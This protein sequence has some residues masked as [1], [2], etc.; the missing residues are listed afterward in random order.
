MNDFVPNS[1]GC[2]S[3]SKW[4]I[5]GG[6]KMGVNYTDYLLKGMIPRSF[7]PF[8]KPPQRQKIHH[9]KN[10]PPGDAIRD[11]DLPEGGVFP[12][13]LPDGHGRRQLRDLGP[14]LVI[15]EVKHLDLT[16]FWLKLPKKSMWGLIAVFW[17]HVC[18]YLRFMR[19]IIWE[20]KLV[21]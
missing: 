4:P 12:V 3:P 21:G 11:L 13:Q 18:E 15:F 10:P 19:F 8:S 16:V 6:H 9:H 20:K 1:W 14:Q 7:S 17:A 2:G 5:Y